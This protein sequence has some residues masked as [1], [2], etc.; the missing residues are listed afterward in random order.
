MI[1]F[2]EGEIIMKKLRLR[3]R[4]DKRALTGS[5]PRRISAV[6]LWC[7]LVFLCCPALCADDMSPI[8]TDTQGTTVNS[9]IAR[10]ELVYHITSPGLSCDHAPVTAFGNIYKTPSTIT[11]KYNVVVPVGGMIAGVHADFIDN[12]FFVSNDGEYTIWEEN[13]STYRRET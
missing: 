12:D 1:H 5:P 8:R 11:G 4:K 2:C 9:R 3:F 6:I 7:A 13:D 10:G